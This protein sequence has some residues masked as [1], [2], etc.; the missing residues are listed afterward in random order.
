MQ[1]FGKL[2]FGIKNFFQVSLPIYIGHLEQNWQKQCN[3]TFIFINFPLFDN[4]SELQI[5]FPAQLKK[6]AEY[7]KTPPL[8]KELHLRISFLQKEKVGSIFFSFHFLSMS[9]R[10][11]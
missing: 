9:D 6:K 2:L 7:L 5:H 10:G 11:H 4:H 8:F 3:R 1:S